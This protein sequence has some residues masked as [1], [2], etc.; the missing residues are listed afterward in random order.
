MTVKV[1]YRLTHIY[2]IHVCLASLQIYFCNVLLRPT[3]AGPAAH[4]AG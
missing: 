4:E 2:V 3:H 1:I